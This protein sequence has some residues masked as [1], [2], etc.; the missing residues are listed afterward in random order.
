MKANGVT[1]QQ[2]KMYDE[3]NVEFNSKA[4][5]LDSNDINIYLVF[6]LPGDDRTGVFSKFANS[7]LSI[8]N[9]FQI[10]NGV[11]SQEFNCAFTDEFAYCATYDDSGTDKN[12]FIFKFDLSD[13]SIPL[14]KEIR[15]ELAASYKVHAA[16]GDD[17][18]LYLSLS[19]T[20]EQIVFRL[21]DTLDT[22]QGRLYDMYGNLTTAKHHGDSIDSLV[23]T[24]NKAIAFFHKDTMNLVIL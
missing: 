7:D 23:V 22:I 2:T 14:K 11:S 3:V 6:T 24:T 16:I 9:S 20:D 13:M 4:M 21:P 19:R 15:T 17:T 18:N 10:Q 1:L 12:M 5:Y 8:K